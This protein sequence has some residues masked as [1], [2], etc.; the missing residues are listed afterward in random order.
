MMD[1]GL[2]YE[3]QGGVPLLGRAGDVLLFVSDVWHRRMPALPGEH[4]RYFLQAHYGRRDIAQRLR[5]SDASHQLSDEAI[6]RARTGRER[7]LVGLHDP[8]FYDG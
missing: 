3:G 2:S 4:G 6:A 1:A 8:L 7:S 5:P